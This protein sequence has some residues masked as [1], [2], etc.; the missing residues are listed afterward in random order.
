MEAQSAKSNLFDRYADF[1][2]GVQGARAL[3]VCDEE[4]H[5]IEP[6]KNVSTTFIPLSIDPFGTDEKDG[7]TKEERES[8]TSKDILVS[9]LCTY[10]YIFTM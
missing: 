5:E 6:W 4:H 9:W 2:G 10:W 8:H 3:N 1:N 7:R